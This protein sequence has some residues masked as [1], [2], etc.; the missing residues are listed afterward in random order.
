MSEGTRIDIN[1]YL[2]RFDA[3]LRELALA[4]REVILAADP[5]FDEAIKWRNPVYEKGGIVC[6][7][8]MYTN[9]VNLEFFRGIELS[10]P[11]GLL[12]GTGKKGKHVKIE[13]VED[14]QPDAF[15]ALIREAAALEER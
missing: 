2:A 6:A 9:H 4:V 10:D 11:E 12:E 8:V 1:A 3:P 7:I 14:I 13:S 15:T 5:E